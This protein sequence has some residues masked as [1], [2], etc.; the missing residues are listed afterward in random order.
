MKDLVFIGDVHL[1]RDD[2][3]VG[4][5]AAFLR[6]LAGH[7]GTVVLIGDLF[8]LW[9]GWRE[10]EQPH[11]QTVIEALAELRAKGVRVL[12]VEGNR[13][14][15]LGGVY[16]G[17]AFDRVVEQGMA[18]EHAGRSWF[19]IHGDLANFED[20]QYRL[21]RKTSRSWLPWLLLRLLPVSRR[22]RWAEKAERRMRRTN[23]RHKRD[24]PEEAIRRYA[25]GF[26]A[27]GHGAVVLG[28]FHLEY[29]SELD[30]GTPVFVLPLWT[31]GRRYL[32]VDGEGAARFEGADAD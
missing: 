30:D 16:E 14:Y 17:T 1:D 9:L 26:A 22:Q 12:Y 28:H 19:A 21:W 10:L 5:F 2:P 4:P 27:A 15:R 24:F 8:N 23:L 32:R 20:R 25:A 31:E 18:V 11:Q 7:A 13:D 29:G 3:N 6:G